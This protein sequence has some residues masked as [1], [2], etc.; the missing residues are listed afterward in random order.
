VLGRCRHPRGKL[1]VHRRCST[2]GRESTAASATSGRWHQHRGRWHQHR[3]IKI[4]CAILMPI[5][6]LLG[7]SLNAGDS[8][9]LLRGTQ[10][11][12]SRWSGK[13]SVAAGSCP[14]PAP[15]CRIVP[16]HDT[17]GPSPRAGKPCTRTAESC[18]GAVDPC[19]MTVKPCT[20]TVHPCTMV[21][22]P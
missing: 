3:A 10:P 11:G 9:P 8:A 19:T 21:V 1:R 12:T 5:R 15:R 20:M 4:G 6:P 22:K 16:S 2:T 14:E 7:G 18:S 17:A 13:H